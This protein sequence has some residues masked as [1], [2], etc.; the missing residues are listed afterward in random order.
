MS[1]K[2][3]KIVKKVSSKIKRKGKKKSAPDYIKV[4]DTTY[5]RVSKHCVDVE[6]DLAE[7]V[8]KRIDTCV[9]RG[10]FVSRGDA[11]RHILRRVLESK[12]PIE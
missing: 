5:E 8:L 2:K 9:R 3:T 11:I 4:Q 10:E 7:D 12:E 6:L 1:R